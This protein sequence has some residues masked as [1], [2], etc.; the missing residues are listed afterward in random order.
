MMAVQSGL[1][2][3]GITILHQLIASLLVALLSA[4]SFRQ[5]GVLTPTLK[6]NTDQSFVEACHG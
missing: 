1:E 4:L 6:V 5:P 3:P 2:Q